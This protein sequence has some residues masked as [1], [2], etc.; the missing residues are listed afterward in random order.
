[1]VS[2]SLTPVVLK[3]RSLRQYLLVPPFVGTLPTDNGVHHSGSST[4][5]L[6]KKTCPNT[7]HAPSTHQREEFS[8]FKSYLLYEC[9]STVNH[10]NLLTI[11]QQFVICGFPLLLWP[12]GSMWHW[13]LILKLYIHLSHTYGSSFDYLKCCSC[14]GSC[15]CAYGPE[16]NVN[17]GIQ[18][19]WMTSRSKPLVSGLQLRCN[20]Q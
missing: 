3:P 18:V 15:S 13:N 8:C 4:D 1:M 19:A 2:G 5:H 7:S 9:I 11:C 12:Q 10:S 6:M 20:M 17:W 16:Q 14:M